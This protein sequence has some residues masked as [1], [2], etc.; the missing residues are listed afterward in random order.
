MIFFVKIACVV[1]IVNNVHGDMKMIMIIKYFKLFYNIIYMNNL[2]KI[3]L[4]VLVAFML[5]NYSCGKKK[6]FLKKEVKE[7]Y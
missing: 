4:V 1:I 5:L 2:M 7:N 6:I 3:I